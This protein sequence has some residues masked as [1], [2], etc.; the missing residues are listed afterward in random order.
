MNEGTN[1]GRWWTPE[2]PRSKV[3]GVLTLSPGD[4]ITLDIAGVLT[5]ATYQGT[6]CGHLQDGVDVTLTGCLVTKSEGLWRARGPRGLGSQQFLVGAALVGGRFPNGADEPFR[7]TEVTYGGIVDWLGTKTFDTIP[8]DAEGYPRVVGLKRASET[9]V[10]FEDVRITMVVGAGEEWTGSKLT[11]ET[12]CKISFFSQRGRTLGEWEKEFV[13]PIGYLASFAVQKPVVVSEQ[14]A[15]RSK[16]W[17][18]YAKARKGIPEIK[19]MRGPSFVK[20][21]EQKVRRTLFTLSD[22][23]VELSDIL[24]RWLEVELELPRFRGQFCASHR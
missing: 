13:N 4:R 5:A 16:S 17:L 10:D 8:I 19:V 6:L 12:R 22:E 3:A 21:D 14:M 20:A 11:L 2:R 18:A 15:L 24:P 7:Y 23:G 1:L 9:S